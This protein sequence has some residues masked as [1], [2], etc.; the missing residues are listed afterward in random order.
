MFKKI[1]FLFLFMGKC[2]TLCPLDTNIRQILQNGFIS[3]NQKYIKHLKDTKAFSSNEQF[4]YTNYNGIF[5]SKPL[6]N[7]GFIKYDFKSLLESQGLDE[8]IAKT[9]HCFNKMF[10]YF[11]FYKIIEG[12]YL[13]RDDK[14]FKKDEFGNIY[15]TMILVKVDLIHNVIFSVHDENS[16]WMKNI[17][18]MRKIIE[19]IKEADYFNM[20][21]KFE[22]KESIRD[23]LLSISINK[24]F[25]LGKLFKK[26]IDKNNYTDDNTL[27]LSLLPEKHEKITWTWFDELN[28]KKL[29]KHH[30]IDILKDYRSNLSCLYKKN[31]EGGSMANEINKINSL[32]DTTINSLWSLIYESPEMTKQ[33]VDQYDYE[34][35]VLRGTLNQWENNKQKEKKLLEQEKKLKELEKISYKQ[36]VV[37]NRRRMNEITNMI[38][39][40]GF[41]IIVI[42][43]IGFTFN[44][45]Y[46][47]INKLMVLAE[48]KFSF[49]T[50]KGLR[51][52]RNNPSFKKIK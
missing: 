6:K 33:D 47:F 26:S 32:M 5:S 19:D 11:F 7:N 36:Q 3:T 51:K 30:F 10:N 38:V 20:N 21:K 13:F 43:G 24:D 42:G 4:F 35:H 9:N 23:K 31:K 29:G 2:F 8:A 40:S 52:S 18:I 34:L 17:I 48:E 15:S 28:M 45:K 14:F 46:K 49:N 22:L 12:L 27:H 39:K 37:N 16:D 44:K 1:L 41:I 50:K 25:I